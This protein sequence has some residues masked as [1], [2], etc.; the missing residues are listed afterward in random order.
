VI[1]LTNETFK[2]NG[3]DFSQHVYYL[4]ITESGNEVKGLPD[5]YTLDGTLHDDVIGTKYTHT[6]ALNPVTEADRK[7]IEA[8]YNAKN[9]Y[10]TYYD[11]A[12]GTDKTVLCKPIPVT[13]RKLLTDPVLYQPSDLI[14]VER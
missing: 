3:K 8:E 10:L 11:K 13:W 7:A 1:R 4:G 2:M 6:Y 9:V 5:R 14:F 12:S